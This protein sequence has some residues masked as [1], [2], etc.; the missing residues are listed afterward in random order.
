M[1]VLVIGGCGFFGHH[2]C[3]YYK[4]KGWD[5]LAYDNLTKFEYLRIPY[6]NVDAVRNYTY[7]LLSSIGVEIWVADVRDMRKVYNAARKCDYIINTCAQPAMTIAIEHPYKDFSTNV[8]GIF[9]IL[10]AARKFSI[11]VAHC[12]TIHVYGNAINSGL[13]PI[14]N[15]FKSLEYPDGIDENV[16]ILNGMV[17]PLH[18]SKRTSEIYMDAYA[19]T[20][21]INAASFRLSGLYG[22][23]QFGG[24]D[25]GWVA[26]FA[27]RHLLGYP[28]KVFGTDKQVRDI[29]YVDDAVRAFDK[30]YEAGCPSGIYNVGGGAKTA[31]SIAQC[32]TELELITGKAVKYEIGDMRMGDLWWF[33]CNVNKFSN[34]T[35]WQPT[36]TPQEGLPKLVEWIKKSEGKLLCNV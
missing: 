24:E 3:Q 34:A 7:D 35:G 5:V 15:Y 26:N 29:L 17:T 22:V 6:I 4:A 23:G 2:I 27:I 30:W 19:K 36:I 32:F 9:N 10:E 8:I 13:I 25:H 18:A 16:P 28:I 20:Y 1:K 14:D 31:I 12:S 33:I 21:G 11:P